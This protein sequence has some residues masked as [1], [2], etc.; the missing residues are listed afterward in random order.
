MQNSQCSPED[1]GP[2]YRL[3]PYPTVAADGQLRDGWLAVQPGLCR[4]CRTKTCA[5]LGA[6]PPQI[7]ILYDTCPRGLSLF[8]SRVDDGVLVVNGVLEPDRNKTSS[9]AARRYKDVRRL[10]TREYVA[11]H[12]GFA[13]ARME[14]RQVVSRAETRGVESLHGVK[15]ATNVVMRNAERVLFAAG[16]NRP[17][18]ELIA[19]AG[20]EV[21][22]LYQSVLILS[23]QLQAVS[24][25]HNPAAAAYG[26]P[27]SVRVHKLCF[28]YAKV[29]EP[30][31]ARRNI[32]VSVQGRS[33][34]APLLYESFGT[35]PLLLID[36][37]VK[38]S[39]NGKEVTVAVEDTGADGVRIEV[40]SFGPG[41][42]PAERPRI[43]EKGFR[44][45]TATRYAGE[46]LGLGLYIAQIIARAHGAQ[47]EYECLDQ[48]G[49]ATCRNIF[50]V[51][52]ASLPKRQ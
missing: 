46:G 34:H 9:S 33:V 36:N 19:D 13:A 45:S 40:A 11:F 14:M 7:G 49:I 5:Q 21:K 16:G 3:V 35:L 25:A 22:S 24:I 31:A 12:E 29:Y 27:R 48:F 32:R 52:V 39:L 43:F 47:L 44:S 51:K 50:R 18:E 17:V 37:A 28:R 2:L 10:T 23:S 20:P 4:R 1:L 38:Y 6:V 41:V 8:A 26:K 30:L 15:T 42:P